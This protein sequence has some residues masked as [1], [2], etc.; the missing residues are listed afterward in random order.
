MWF[1]ADPPH[2]AMETRH[3]GRRARPAEETS[4]E[5]R[6]VAAGRP[7]SAT[8]SAALLGVQRHDATLRPARS[9]VT[10]ALVLVAEPPTR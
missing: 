8:G 7:A 6:E 2:P 9:L 3:H 10:P 4:S 5:G 1:F